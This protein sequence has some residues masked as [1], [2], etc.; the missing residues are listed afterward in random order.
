[1]T[2]TQNPGPAPPGPAPYEAYSEARMGFGEKP[3]VVVVDFMLA[4]TDPRFALGR[5]AH[6][7]RAVE[8]TATLLAAARAAGAPVASCYTAYSS[9]RDAPHW[10]VRAVM[11][12]FRHGWEGAK[13]DPRIYDP[14][15]DAIYCKTGPSIFFGTSVAQYFAKERV[16]TVIV[17]GCTTSGC[18]RA[19]V[20]DAFS[21]GFRVIVPEPCC[22]D[23]DEGPHWDNLRDVGR[24]YAD[25]VGLEETVAYLDAQR[26][27]N[28]PL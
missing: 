10:K 28:R 19:S 20:I 21:Y 5:S 13:L 24:R 1:M 18:V 8:N 26:M 27:R 15:Y 22:G 16:D 9:E 6:V 2:D 3:G 25:V 4:F 11:E 17:A 14:A 7:N 12:E 23:M